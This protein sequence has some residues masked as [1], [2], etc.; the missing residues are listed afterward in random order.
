[1]LLFSLEAVLVYLFV[2][3]NLVIFYV[4]FELSLLPL[5]MLIGM[6]G[7]S[8]ERLRA[9]KLLWAYTFIGSL[10]LLLSIV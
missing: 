2:T 6:Y 7:A 1:M 10:C 4:L 8:S 3:D 9:S 5:Y